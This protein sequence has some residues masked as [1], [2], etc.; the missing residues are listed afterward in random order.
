MK[1]KDW[2]DL[3]K[4]IKDILSSASRK[5]TNEKK[6]KNEKRKENLANHNKNNNNNN[7]SNRRTKRD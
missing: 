5:I 3:Q 4:K 1:N 2:V 7:K 6:G